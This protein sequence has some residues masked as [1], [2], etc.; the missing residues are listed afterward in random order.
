MME[1]QKAAFFCVTRRGFLLD[2]P[3]FLRRKKKEEGEFA[4]DFGEAAQT[5]LTYFSPKKKKTCILGPHHSSLYFECVPG[6]RVALK[7][8]FCFEFRYLFL[9]K[10]SE[11]KRPF[12]PVQQEKEEKE[13]EEEEEEEEEAWSHLISERRRKRGKKKKPASPGH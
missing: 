4:L 1:S 6:K 9:S 2:G 3:A 5:V 8:H 12:F 13:E 11:M 10:W 7:K